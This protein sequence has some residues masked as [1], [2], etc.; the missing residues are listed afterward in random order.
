[1]TAPKGYHEVLRDGRL[2]GYAPDKEDYAI[3]EILL[4][5]HVTSWELVS[6]KGS[7]SFIG[8]KAQAIQ[9]AKNMQA[10]LQASFGVDVV[11]N[12]QTVYTAE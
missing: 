7:R 4:L 10:K 5:E 9:E 6:V 12:G 1:M 11:G 2:L 3:D 8:S